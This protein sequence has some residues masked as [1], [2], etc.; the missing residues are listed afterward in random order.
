MRVTGDSDAIES[1]LFLFL[2][3]PMNHGIYQH[4]VAVILGG[5]GMVLGGGLLTRGWMA[6]TRVMLV[7][8][9]VSSPLVVRGGSVV[10]M[11]VALM[12]IMAPLSTP[13]LAWSGVGG[14]GPSIIHASPILNPL[15]PDFF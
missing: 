8:V 4:L 5:R 7:S 3:D 9:S 11:V 15:V 12:V 10:L 6:L 13:V 2:R 14:R 1:R